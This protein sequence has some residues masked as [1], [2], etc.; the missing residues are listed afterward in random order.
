MTI[1]ISQ[2]QLKPDRQNSIRIHREK[3]YIGDRLSVYEN[4][5][6]SYNSNI[7]IN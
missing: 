5:T 4:D 6:Y 7:N 2:N 3:L 1:E